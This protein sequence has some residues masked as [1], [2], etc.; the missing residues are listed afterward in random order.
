[1][2]VWMMGGRGTVGGATAP[3]RAVNQTAEGVVVSASRLPRRGHIQPDVPAAEELLFR[4][5]TITWRTA[6]AA[7]DRTGPAGV[8][9]AGVRRS[10]VQLFRP[11]PVAVLQTLNAAGTCGHSAGRALRT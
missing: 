10:P 1:M 6:T 7:D 9:V 8:G 11:V 3:D 4:A 2:F 5:H